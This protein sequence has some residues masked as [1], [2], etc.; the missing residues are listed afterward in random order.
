M[1]PHPVIVPEIF[2]LRPDFT[3][4]RLA[5]AGGANRAGDA[6]SSGPLAEAVAGLDPAAPWAEAHLA[7]RRDTCRGFGAKPGRPP[8]SAE[9][10]RKRTLRDGGLPPANAVPVGGEDAGACA[11]APTLCRATGNGAFDSM[12]KGVPVTAP[13]EAGAVIRCDGQGVTCRRRNRR[14]GRGRQLTKASRALWFVP[15][16]LEPMPIAALTEAGRA[17][18]HGLRVLAPRAVVTAAILDQASP[19]GRPLALEG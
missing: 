3:V 17:L 8:G 4:L 12:A 11:G 1:M 7:A 2:A 16:R 13:P 18:A 5:V 14:Q 15:E 9:A 19:E 10:L 6:A